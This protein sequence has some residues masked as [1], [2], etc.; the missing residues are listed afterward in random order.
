MTAVSFDA[1]EDGWPD[2]FVACDSTPS[3][4]FMNNHDGTFREEALVRGL[5]VSGDGQEM[6]GMGVGLGDY[7][8]DGHTDVF[9]THFQLQSSG[10]YRSSGKGDF[11]DV[12]IAAG[13][14]N[15]RRFVSWG[16][17]IVDLDNDGLPDLFCVTGNV[18]PSLERTFANIPPKVRPL[19]SGTWVMASSWKW[20][21]MPP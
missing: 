9:K 1:D 3:L 16:A 18:Y 14:G 6:G 12:S 20:A 10:L 7:N 17:G 8:L 4:L 11:D 5:A 15:E 19:F 13:I 21:T 2:I